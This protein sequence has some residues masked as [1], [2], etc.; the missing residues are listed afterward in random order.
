MHLAELPMIAFFVLSGFL[1]TRIL[2]AEYEKTGGILLGR[3]FLRRALRILP[4]SYVYLLRLAGFAAAGVVR[5]APHDLGYAAAFVINA[6]PDRSW[7]VG[8]IWSLSIECQFYL[9]W[10]L[11]FWK[12][13]P[14]RSAWVAAGLIGLAPCARVLAWLFLRHTPYYDLEFFPVFADCLA[15]GCLLARL[16]SWL[17]EQDWYRRLFHP[18][19]SILLLLSAV[20]VERLMVYSIVRFFGTTFISAALAILIHRSMY[21]SNDL[22]GRILNSRVLKFLGLSSYSLYIWQQPF[23][24]RESSA[25]T[26]AFPQNL[27]LSFAAAMT[28]YFLLER[29]LLKSRAALSPGIPRAINFEAGVAD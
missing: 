16:H 8:H 9:L 26:S 12:M 11:V 5:L 28:S 23:L 1:I 6:T 15:I 29:T 14:R 13:G 24:N 21:R 3:F 4:V 27:V 25:W 19:A 18:R 7:F 20:V 22:S 10:G 17:E 2:T